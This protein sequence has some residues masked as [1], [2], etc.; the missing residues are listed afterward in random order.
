MDWVNKILRVGHQLIL[1]QDNGYLEVVDINTSKITSTHQFE[2]IN[3]ISDILAI[4]DSQ[5]LVA[6]YGGL[7]K[8]TK[9][10]VLKSS[11]TGELISSLCQ[12]T[13]KV[14]LVGLIDDQLEVWNEQTDQKLFKVSIPWVFSIKR[15]LDSNYFI[16]KTMRDGV[17]VLTINDLKSGQFYLQHLL[18][19][20]EGYNWNYTDSLQ[21]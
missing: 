20:E 8:T 7:L 11:Y 14:Y 19:S 3:D 4:D 18:D 13:E 16:L 1:G 9:D 6:A 10:Q 5:Y 2:G 17:Q 12:I 21:V 15:V